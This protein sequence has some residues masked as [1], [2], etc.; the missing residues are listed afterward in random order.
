MFHVLL[1]AY[2]CA[3]SFISCS[4]FLVSNESSSFQAPSMDNSLEYT[5]NFVVCFPPF[6]MFILNVALKQIAYNSTFKNNG[7]KHHYRQFLLYIFEVLVLETS[8][9]KGK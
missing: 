7:M 1:C 4:C 8:G 2:K 3:L 6:F 9:T 5:F